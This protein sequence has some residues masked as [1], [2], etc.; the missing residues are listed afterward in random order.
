MPSAAFYNLFGRVRIVPVFLESQ[1]MTTP[2]QKYRWRQWLHWTLQLLAGAAGL[3]FGFDFGYRLD[4]AG[5]GILMALN[6]A[7]FCSIMAGAVVERL[8]P[9]GKAERDQA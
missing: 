1:P 3:K 4:G 2:Q 5:I 6:S 8:L 9:L 7:L